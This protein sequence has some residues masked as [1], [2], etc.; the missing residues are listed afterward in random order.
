MA[1]KI[2]LATPYDG[3]IG[4]IAKWAQHIIGYYNSIEEKECEIDILQMNRK[5]FT[6]INSAFKRAYYG[7]CD[8]HSFLVK[9]EDMVKAQKYDIFH[10]ASSA[11]ISLLKDFAMLRAAKKRGVKT[12]VH[13]HFGRIPEL[14]VKKNWEWK[15][16]CKVVKL[17]D[18]TIVLDKASY[19]TL[20]NAG[21]KN[22]VLLPNPVAPRVTEL[23]EK[24]EI[25]ERKERTLLFAGHGIRTKGIYE[26]I[27]ACKQ[28]PNIKLRMIGNIASDVKTELEAMA[29]NAEWLDIAG[30]YPYEKTI[31][32]MLTRDVF[33]L[34][35]YTEGFPNVILESMACGCAIVTTP[36]GAIPE[37]LEE[38]NGKHYGILV[39]PRNVQELKEGIEAMLNN[40]TLKQECRKNAKQRVNERYNIDAVW[41]HMVDIWSNTIK[42]TY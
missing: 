42:Q 19:D 35:T 8:Y 29:E 7:I 24:T 10:L 28:I 38:E 17:S 20:H 14:S 11:S 31:A 21:H 41:K 12:V 32:E 25:A 33:V 2:L 22:V 34:P 5:S 3:A 13:F 18:T 36:V 39:A 27:E 40:E 1:M 37:M 16:I 30:E 23:I 4:G 6:N 26:L 9:E 15:M